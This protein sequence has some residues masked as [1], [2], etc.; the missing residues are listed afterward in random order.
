MTL[1]GVS[2]LPILMVTITISRVLNIGE[3]VRTMF[4]L[5]SVRNLV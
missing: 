4:S 1:E 5:S 2:V 3:R